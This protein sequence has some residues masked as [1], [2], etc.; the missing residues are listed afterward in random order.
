M[1]GTE[2]VQAAIRLARRHRL[3]VGAQPV[4]HGATAATT[5][6]MILLRT[7]A[8]D[9]IDLVGDVVRIGAGVRWRDLNNALAGTGLTS[10]PGS[11]GDTSVVGYTLGGGVSWFGRKWGQA[12]NRVRAIELV[13]AEGHHLR[14]TKDAF[15]DL[16]WALRGGG[17]EFAIVTAMELD[18]L[19]GTADLR[20][21]DDVVR[22]GRAGPA[23][24]LL[25]C[26]R[27]R[28]GRAQPVGL[29]AA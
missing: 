5:G 8:L 1:T 21:P 3:T 29:A 18:L 13:D 25:D 17:G 27:D 19:A 9:A 15:P 20:R 14:V 22:R 7:G 16:F 28:T 2:D 23:A 12:A 10:L 4:G 24:R 6:G 11:N 26:Q